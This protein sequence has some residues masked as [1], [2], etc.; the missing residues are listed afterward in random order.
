M[1]RAQARPWALGRCGPGSRAAA[2][3]PGPGLG[4]AHVRTLLAIYVYVYGCM[5]MYMH[6]CMY[7]GVQN[8]RKSEFQEMCWP[9]G[10]IIPTPRGS[11]LDPTRASQVPY[12][13]ILF[14]GDFFNFPPLW[15]ALNLNPACFCSP[16]GRA[17]LLQRRL[18]RPRPRRV[19]FLPAW[20]LW[21][22]KGHVQGDK[23]PKK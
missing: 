2:Q 17:A 18:C 3:G 14:L 11:I 21:R 10:Q 22:L 7:L 16:Q 15:G 8:H 4:P 19:R 12:R 13:V 20:H 5:Y 23:S 9:G 1:G 6:I